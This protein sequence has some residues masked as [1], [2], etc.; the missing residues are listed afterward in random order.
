MEPVRQTAQ[1]WNPSSLVSEATALGM[2]CS[3]YHA[4]E[5]WSRT[6][7]SLGE[8]LHGHDSR[9]SR[10]HR[11]GTLGIWYPKT[12]KPCVDLCLASVIQTGGCEV[13]PDCPEG[14]VNCGW[15]RKTCVC[16]KVPLLM[17]T[18]VVSQC[19][20]I[21]RLPAVNDRP[22]DYKLWGCAAQLLNP[23]DTQQI[24]KVRRDTA[25][26]HAE[27]A[28]PTHEH[29]K[30]PLMDEH[31]GEYSYDAPSQY[32]NL[33]SSGGAYPTLYRARQTGV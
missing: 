18:C 19:E 30:T 29:D 10:K 33:M 27:D 7:P 15:A 20:G 32:K 4:E 24:V 13:T 8:Q 22:G 12:N 25:P 14:G 5:E 21:F 26:A 16:K 9:R 1:L 6:L 31:G 23:V 11:N 28:R 17:S 3:N 2:I